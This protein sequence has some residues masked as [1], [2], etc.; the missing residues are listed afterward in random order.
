MFAHMV[1]P[2][3]TMNFWMH[4]LLAYVVTLALGSQPRRGLA[5]GWAKRKLVSHIS[6]SQKCKKVW[7][8]KPSHSQWSSH[9]GSWSFDG[10]TNLH[11]S[12]TRVKTQWIEKLFI[13]LEIFWNVN[14][15]NGLA[16]SIS[17]SE[18]QVMTKEGSEIKSSIWYP[19]TKSRK[20]PQFPCVQGV[21]DISFKNFRWGLQ[22]CFKLHL[23]QM[24][25]HKV[26]GPQSCG[27]PSCGNFGTPTWE[28][29]DK[30][31]FEC[32]SHGQA[33]SIL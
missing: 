9:F 28:S 18:T 11:T 25:T 23:I 27:S 19:T 21:C 32:W 7:G 20:S 3:W 33:Q 5:T 24:S 8:N 10:F 13:P 14:V 31:S 4:C 26:I 17:I 30:M 2:C 15:W 22:L 12:I 1:G 16:W 29:R 6:C